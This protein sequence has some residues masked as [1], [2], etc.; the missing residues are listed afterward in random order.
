MDYMF[1]DE[2]MVWK[3]FYRDLF[4]I[5]MY[6]TWHVNQK[7][8]FKRIFMINVG[9]QQMQHYQ[10]YARSW[11]AWHELYDKWI[12]SS[13]NVFKMMKCSAICG[14]VKF[15]H[16]C[17]W[18]LKMNNVYNKLNFDESRCT[19]YGIDNCPLSNYTTTSNGGNMILCF[20]CYKKYVV[21]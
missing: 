3:L 2:L 21:F 16:Q 17:K 20:K 10:P 14:I 13:T 4:Y 11:S 19:P 1:N 6:I 9:L 7:W 5:N 15:N 18:F 8:G 12:N